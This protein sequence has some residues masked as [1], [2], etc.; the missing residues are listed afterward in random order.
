MPLA[1]YLIIA[2]SGRAL[3]ASA[4][5]GNCPAHVIDHFA[6]LDTCE[7]ALSVKQIPYTDKSFAKGIL[8][9]AIK[10]SCLEHPGIELVPGSGF[11]QQT[12]LI[13]ILSDIAPCLGNSAEVIRKVKD[14]NCFFGLL[15][16]LGIP[17][18]ETTTLLQNAGH[19]WLCKTIG[20]MGGDHIVRYHNCNIPAGRGVYFQQFIEGQSYSALFLA[21]GKQACVLGFSELWHANEF[22][23]TPFKYAG[24]IS[25]TTQP[26]MFSNWIPDIPDM[27]CKLVAASG[28]KG[29]CGLDFILDRE[30]QLHVLEVNPRPPA[31]FELHER[32]RNLFSAH[33]QA[34]HGYLPEQ[35]PMLDEHIHALTILYARQTLIIPAQMKWPSWTADRPRPG[36]KISFAEPVCTIKANGGE[37]SKVK[38]LLYDRRFALEAE[39]LRWQDA[40]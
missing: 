36:R 21:N 39:L 24:A 31:T 4:N 25:L 32:G 1:K 19:D 14:P 13:Q 34:C 22:P 18:P 30:N 23:D 5:R 2:Q 7:M 33:L 3:A 29:L 27:I 16:E 11:E 8:Q 35:A 40:A 37:Q 17:H 20:G 10:N 12:A 38:K 9:E 15:D 28:L 6:D 26:E